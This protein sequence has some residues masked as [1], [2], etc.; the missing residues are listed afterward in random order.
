[1]IPDWDRYDLVVF[2]VDGTLYDQ[3]ALRRRLLPRLALSCLWMCDLTTLR[4]ISALRTERERLATEE[5]EDFEAVL[6]S[7]VA[8]KIGVSEK[9]VRQTLIEWLERRPLS[10]LPACRTPGAQELFGGL[11]AEGRIVAVLSDYAAD[12][13]LASLGL[14]ADIVVAATDHEIRIQKP[15]P[16]GLLHIIAKAGSKPCRTLVIGDRLDRD[17]AVANRVGTDSLLRGRSA[18]FLSFDDPIFAPVT[19]GGALGHLRAA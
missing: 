15:N 9:I 8:A 4:L 18:D 5:V 7:R 12:D 11:R 13:K 16:R 17:R 6:L 1:M 3:R 19:G 10:S 14:L 2:D